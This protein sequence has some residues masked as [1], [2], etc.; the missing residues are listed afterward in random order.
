MTSGS[1]GEPKRIARDAASLE[2][3][4]RNLAKEFGKG[5]AGA[6]GFSASVRTEHFYGRLWIDMLPRFVSLAPPRRTVV[7]V[8]ELAE[9]V[10]GGKSVFVTTPSFLEKALSHPD[11]AS[12]RGS[13]ADIVVSG[14]PLHESTAAAV[15]KAVGVCPLEIYGSTEAGTIASR[16]RSLSP[17]FV[18]VSGVEGRMDESGRLVVVSPFAMEKTLVMSDAVEFCGERAF[19]LLGRTDRLVKIRERFVS[20]DAV[21]KALESHPWIRRAA[22]VPMQSGGVVRTGALAVLSDAGL[23]AL[24]SGTYASVASAV[25]RAAMPLVGAAAYPRRIRF[26]RELPVDSR[27]KTTTAAVSRTLDANCR[28]PAVVSWSATA[29]SLVAELVFPP[30]GEWFAGHFPGFPVLPGV[31]QLFFTRHYSRQA[32]GDF[33]GAATFKR[34]KFRRLVR[35]GEKVKLSVS[36]NDA[37]RFDFEMSVDGNPAS[38]GSVEG[39]S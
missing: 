9:E 32:F 1:T 24:S 7:S 23:E 13:F 35:P 39:A 37:G 14:G 10:S 18:F 33:P 26:V 31:A 3:D 2:A 19:R 27:G 25:R 15:E 17:H 34:L 6:T 38:S 28:E 22:A 30:D 16:R 21:E 4:A 20:L 8:E 5:F 11:F 29:S 36:R 12:L